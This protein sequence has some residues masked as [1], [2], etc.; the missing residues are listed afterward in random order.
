MQTA[1]GL[2]SSL[3]LSAAGSLLA[4][5]ATAAAQDVQSKPFSLV[6]QAPSDKSLDGQKLAACHTGAAIE[7]L[8]L[9]GSSGA[10]SSFFLN[11]TQGAQPPQPGY[12][13]AGVL[14]WNLPS[15]GGVPGGGVVSEP[16]SFSVDPSTNV[17]LP[18]FQPGSGTTQYVAFDTTAAKD[19]ARLVV[20]S[21]LDDTRRPP[22]EDK[23]R[24]LSNWH[25][26]Q[27]YYAGYQYR[28]LNW[29]LG[30][31]G[32]KPQNPSCVKVEV[33]RKFT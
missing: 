1:A 31:G 23:P 29:V 33:Q 14:V 7:S 5:A 10:G 28:T 13:P 3:L 9:G 25:V 22:T 27:T 32:Q 21:S 8:C 19:A 15:G 18:L 12:E 26:C 11:T 4:G 24:A 20:F 6:V 17:A 2:V 30:N 16:M